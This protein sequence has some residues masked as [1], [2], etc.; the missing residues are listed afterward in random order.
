MMRGLDPG[1]WIFQGMILCPDC[2]CKR[3]PKASYHGHACTGSNDSRQP[4]SVYGDFRVDTSWLGDF[5]SVRAELDAIRS[6]R[7]K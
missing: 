4:G 1:E 6:E 5:D 3:C 2:G 7:G